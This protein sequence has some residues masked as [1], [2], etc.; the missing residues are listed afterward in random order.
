MDFILVPSAC[1][2]SLWHGHW[3]FG[4]FFIRR[5]QLTA[6]SC[7]SDQHH[8]ISIYVIK[9]KIVV[10]FVLLRLKHSNGLRELVI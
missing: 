2:I 6:C 7:H 10:G 4:E 8:L 1:V 9:P 3:L 5:A